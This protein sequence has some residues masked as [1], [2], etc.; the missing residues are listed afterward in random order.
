LNFYGPSALRK[1]LSIDKFGF[2]VLYGQIEEK[3][4]TTDSKQQLLSG[5]TCY[6]SHTAYIDDVLGFHSVGNPNST[7]AITLAL[8][9]PGNF[10]SLK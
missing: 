10:T 9:M 7:P 1:N 2:K 3:R 4:Y 8:Y 6:R 5:N